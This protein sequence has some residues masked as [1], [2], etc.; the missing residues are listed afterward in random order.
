[1]AAKGW[2][3]SAHEMSRAEPIGLSTKAKKFPVPPPYV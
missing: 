3:A 1:M 2:Q